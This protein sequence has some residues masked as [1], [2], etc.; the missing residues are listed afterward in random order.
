MVEGAGLPTYNEGRWAGTWIVPGGDNGIPS[1]NNR[2]LGDPIGENEEGSAHDNEESDEGLN[3]IV[4]DNDSSEDGEQLEEGFDTSFDNNKLEIEEGEIMTTSDENKLKIYKM[5]LVLGRKRHFV[6]AIGQSPGTRAVFGA[7][8]KLEGGVLLRSIEVRVCRRRGL[9]IFT[10]KEHLGCTNPM[11]FVSETV[12]QNY[13]RLSDEQKSNVS[14]L[15]GAVQVSMNGDLDA[16]DSLETNADILKEIHVKIP[17]DIKLVDPEVTYDLFAETTHNGDVVFVQV[18]LDSGEPVTG[19]CFYVFAIFRRQLTSRDTTI[20]EADRA[21]RMVL[22]TRQSNVGRAPPAQAGPF[23]P[24]AAPISASPSPAPAPHPQSVPM[25]SEH[26]NTP[27]SFP[28]ESQAQRQHLDL[29]MNQLNNL[30]TRQAQTEQQNQALMASMQQLT[31]SLRQSNLAT[32][33]APTFARPRG[34]VFTSRGGTHRP[35]TTNNSTTPTP[36]ALSR[37]HSESMEEEAR[38][39]SPPQAMQRTNSDPDEVFF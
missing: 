20:M 34:P 14:L 31:E 2:G 35:T 21:N 36:P 13:P 26:Y 27:G 15:V 30:N 22:S 39:E 8:A 11:K 33:P 16:R 5:R 17:S 24:P 9:V 1:H 37:P 38:I 7:H 25:V 29:M 28:I 19:P 12:R 6:H 18:E 3:G 23:Q 32:K 10:F 4:E